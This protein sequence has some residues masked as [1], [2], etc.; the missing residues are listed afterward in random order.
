MVEIGRIE[1][2]TE[3]S[4]V[5][6]HS[7]LPCEGLLDTALYIIVYLGLHHNSSLYMDSTYTNTN[8]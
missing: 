3:V 7:A 5:L 1:I 8:G 2:A 6:S 4:L